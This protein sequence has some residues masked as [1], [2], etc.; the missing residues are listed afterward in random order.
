[1]SWL[2]FLIVALLTWCNS[3]LFSRSVGPDA[4]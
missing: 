4:A 3:R 1:V 2:L